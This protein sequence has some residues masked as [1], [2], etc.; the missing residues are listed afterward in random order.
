ME[1]EIGEKYFEIV[2]RSESYFRFSHALAKVSC[3]VI[4]YSRFGEIFLKCLRTVKKAGVTR[5]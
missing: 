4:S 3:F 1:G 5:V 2:D